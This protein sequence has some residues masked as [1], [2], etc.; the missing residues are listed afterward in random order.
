MFICALHMAEIS[1]YFVINMTTLSKFFKP[2]KIY[3]FFYYLV[4]SL[5]VLFIFK[6]L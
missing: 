4:Y 6:K 3:S 2:K 1:S 5:Y